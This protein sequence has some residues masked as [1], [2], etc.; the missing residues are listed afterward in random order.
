MSTRSITIRVFF[1]SD[2][3]DP[4]LLAGTVAGR[5]ASDVDDSGQWP[6]RA[7]NAPGVTRVEAWPTPWAEDQPNPDAT[8]SVEVALFGLQRGVSP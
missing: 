8:D 5:V 6:H 3:A 4:E 2:I 1:D 7:A